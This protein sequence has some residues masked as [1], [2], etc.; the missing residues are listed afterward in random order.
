MRQFWFSGH[1]N[2]RADPETDPDSVAPTTQRRT[3][4]WLSCWR[5][6]C[7]VDGDITDNVSSALLLQQF[8]SHP[9]AV[10]IRTECCCVLVDT[11]ISTLHRDIVADQGDRRPEGPSSSNCCHFSLHF[12][13]CPQNLQYCPRPITVIRFECDEQTNGQTNCLY[14][15]YCNTNIW[16]STVWCSDELTTRSQV[17]TSWRAWSAYCCC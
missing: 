12:I 3:V 13:S 4:C 6:A 14:V 7:T 8:V 17:A 1:S 9:Q 2:P 11:R 5:A 10:D 16:H 15:W